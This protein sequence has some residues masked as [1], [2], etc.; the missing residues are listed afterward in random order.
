MEG[1]INQIISALIL[2][3]L[4]FEDASET[5]VPDK[6]KKIYPQGGTSLR[7]SI[8]NGCKLLIDLLQLLQKTGTADRWNFAHVI[9][10]DGLDEHSKSSLE[11]TLALMAV[12]GQKLNVKSLKIIL[13]GVGVSAK[14]ENELKL[15]AKAGGEN[16]DYYSVGNTE[17]GKIFQRITVNLGLQKRQEVMGVTSNQ[18][19][20][21]FVQEKVSPMLSLQLQRFAVLLNLDVSGSMSGQKWS[22]LCQAVDRFADFLGEQDLLAALVFNHQTKLL[23]KMD[24]DDDLFKNP[25]GNSKGGSTIV[26]QTS[27]GQKV[28]MNP[29][30]CIIY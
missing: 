29:E 27:S 10:T 17:I 2:E 22:S 11:Q 26:I 20:A 12:I 5:T 30:D 18:G 16:A 3:E 25:N 19:T 24:E 8:F 23:S 1:Q 13:I 14:A 21:L 15:L 28:Q 6:L 7:D 4:G 9:L